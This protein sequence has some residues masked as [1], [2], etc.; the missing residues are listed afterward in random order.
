MKPNFYSLLAYSYLQADV[1]SSGADRINREIIDNHNLDE[2]WEQYGK[3]LNFSRATSYYS[4]FLEGFRILYG[5]N[6]SFF[7][8]ENIVSLSDKI[9]ANYQDYHSWFDQAFEQAGFEVMFIDQYWNQ[10]NTKID[11]QHFALVFNINK[12][13]SS[14]SQ[15]PERIK[16]GEPV[17]PYVY[18]LAVKQGKNIKT[19]D[20]YLAIADY[21]FEEFMDNH[22]VCIKNSMAYGRSI[23]YE[24]I[25]YE[26][27]KNL[28]RKNSSDLSAVEKKNLQD[29]MFHWI[30][31]KSIELNLPIQIHTGYLAGNGNTLE[32]SHPIKLNALFLRYP[33][34]R[35]VLF[36]G[37]YP[38]TGGYAALG[39]MFKNVY[40]DIVWLPQISREAA[41][42]AL[43]EMFDC[44]P[45]N[46]FFWGGD[47]D[48][49]EETTGSLEFGKE[50]VAQVLAGRIERGLMTEE[51][52]FEIA[53]GIFRDNAIEV[54]D[55]ESKLNR[56]LLITS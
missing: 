33:D 28:F 44:V 14:I 10:F 38:W 46:K 49:I 43:V 39:K 22:V 55:L 54:F 25:S 23:D 11:T 37:G 32:N 1:V 20:D 29:F 5:F 41:V 13:V 19:L 7:T 27:A 52:A 31:K 4:H 24:E 45:Y 6:D 35:F 50:V 26:K 30:I 2:L 12:L 3:Y 42:R 15:R 51:V 36:H 53:R 34:A 8:K 56:E 9:A 16:K 18:E 17:K 21:L 47:C 48:L 40:L